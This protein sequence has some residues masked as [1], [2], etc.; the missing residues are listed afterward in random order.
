MKTGKPSLSKRGILCDMDGVIY[1]GSRILPGA[2]DFVDWLRRTD[3]PFL[4]I[5]NS[6][7]RSPRELSEKLRRMGADIEEFHFYTSAMAT[8]A[9]LSSQT[10]GGS[11]YVIGQPGLIN[12]LY[13]AGFSTNDVNPD[14]VVVGE[15][16][17]Y[18]YD[19]MK[20][21]VSLVLG[22]AKLIGTNPDVTG[23]SESGII[24]A[25]GALVAP[26]ELATGVKAYF[27]GKPNPLMMRTGLGLLGC[28][29]ESALIVGD[30]MD[31]DIISGIESGI[32]TVLVLSGVARREDLARFG[33]SPD[34]VLEHV[35][36]LPALLGPTLQA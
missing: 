14:Y 23:P 8:A 1:H 2:A 19:T 7:E 9:F 18:T 16:P 20:K 17:T 27:V 5:T 26:I 35:G 13:D 4:F 22:G 11:A 3:T 32:E 21:A 24:P 10:P 28:P 6:S 31:T 15:T 25:C 30:R 34:Y 29:R 36:Q 33:F 12:A